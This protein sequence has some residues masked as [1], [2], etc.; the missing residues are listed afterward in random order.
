MCPYLKVHK[1]PTNMTLETFTKLLPLI[2]R[3]PHISIIGAGEP[4]INNNLIHFIKLAKEANPSATIDLTT[5]GTL[6]T[7]YLCTKFVNL[8]LNK[9]VFSIDGA[10][11]QTVESIRLG[12]NFS[13]VVENIKLLY[14]IKEEMESSHPIIRAN[15]AVG[16]GNY[17]H[18]PDFIMLAKRI[19]I[20]EINFMEIQAANYVD[21]KENLLNSIIKDESRILKEAINLAKENRINISLPVIHESVCHAPYVPH[22]SEQGE[23]FPCCYYAYDRKLYSEGKEVNIPTFSFG[24]TNRESFR[25]IWNSHSYKKLR[26]SCDT[27]NFNKSCSACYNAKID[28]SH[29]VKE[30]LNEIGADYRE[31]GS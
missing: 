20:N 27:G 12:V 4:T 24:N 25:S 21:Y 1:N 18:L 14:R 22:I 28:S 19:G 8:R 11:A 17:S 30:I 6:L 2:E 26:R 3:I 5:N 7:E 31:Y 16:Y 13:E 23:A 29:K 9:V 10:N 15:H